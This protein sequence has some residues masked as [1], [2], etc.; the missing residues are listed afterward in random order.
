MC[1]RG[2]YWWITHICQRM[3]DPLCS[4]WI[5]DR[6]SHNIHLSQKINSY[7]SLEV[8]SEAW[9]TTPLSQSSEICCFVKWSSWSILM[10]CSPTTGLSKS[11]VI[12]NLV[13]DITY[14][15]KVSWIEWN[16]GVRGRTVKLP[17]PILFTHWVTCWRVCGLF[18][19]GNLLKA[20]QQY[21]R[22][23]HF[24][25]LKKYTLLYWVYPVTILFSH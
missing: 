22:P 23:V 18:L 14:Y 1:H 24:P 17:A 4:W 19:S 9:Y 5:C 10:V 8:G 20:S 11:T 12:A 13:T 16:L 25:C 3:S 7:Y 15:K 21:K 2:Q 6:F